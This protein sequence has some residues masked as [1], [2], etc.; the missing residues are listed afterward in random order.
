MKMNMLPE[1]LNVRLYVTTVVE[2]E[3]LNYHDSGYF[4][5]SLL[6]LMTQSFVTQGQ[7]QNGARVAVI[8]LVDTPLNE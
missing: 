1:D 6:F 7:M 5:Y 3:S 2:V 8:T 4:N